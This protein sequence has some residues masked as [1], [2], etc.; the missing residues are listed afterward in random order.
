M[1]NKFFWPALLW[2]IFVTVLCL[3]S[4]SSLESMN[5]VEIPYKDKVLHFVFYFVFTGSWYMHFREKYGH[6]MKVK[7]FV[8]L[9]AI[10]YGGFIELCQ[11]LFT[12]GRSA[13]ILD[14]LA[15]TLGSATAVT[16]AWLY[17]RFR[18]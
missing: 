9:F 7:L 1:R 5:V 2:T 12:N 15:N 3:V 8:F 18:K 6:N 13:D 14:A 17:R 4:S 11:L 16:C 10:L